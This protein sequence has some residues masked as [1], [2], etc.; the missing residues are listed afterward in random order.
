MGPVGDEAAPALTQTWPRPWLP[1]DAGQGG[2]LAVPRDFRESWLL[3]LKNWEI[4]STSQ[5]RLRI[6][7]VKPGGS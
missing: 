3:C 1:T 2:C 4:I 7:H 6:G 5:G